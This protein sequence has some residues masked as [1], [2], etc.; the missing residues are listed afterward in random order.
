MDADPG[1]TLV[2][3]YLAWHNGWAQIGKCIQASTD[4]KQ[5]TLWALVAGQG[6]PLVAAGGVQQTRVVVQLTWLRSCFWAIH[7]GQ[8]VAIASQLVLSVESTSGLWVTDDEPT[9]RWQRE[10]LHRWPLLC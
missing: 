1:Q 7:A 6:V 5:A 4:G 10:A 9:R 2:P 3:T 8:H